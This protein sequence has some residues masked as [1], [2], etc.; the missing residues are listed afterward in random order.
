MDLK[1]CTETLRERMSDA[2]GL[3]ASLKFD[4]GADGVLFVDARSIPHH[5]NNADLDADCTVSISLANLSALIR[6]SSI[7][8]S[9]S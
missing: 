5:V 1:T 7:R 6:A 3:D 8:Q 2:S 9:V 4:C